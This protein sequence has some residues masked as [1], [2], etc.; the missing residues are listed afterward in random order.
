MA[1]DDHD[2]LPQGR[3]ITGKA[4]KTP[5][6]AIGATAAVVAIFFLVA[7]GLAALAY[8]LAG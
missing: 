7:L 2:Q 6:V 1:I 8:V 5:L 3:V 4:D